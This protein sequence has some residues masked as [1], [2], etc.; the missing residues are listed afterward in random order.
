MPST[1]VIHVKSKRLVLLLVVLFFFSIVIPLLLRLRIREFARLRIY[2]ADPLHVRCR[3]TCQRRYTPTLDDD[4]TYCRPCMSVNRPFFFQGFLRL[5]SYLLN[6]YIQGQAAIQ[7]LM[8]SMTIKSCFDSVLLPL[9][10]CCE[11][12]P[13]EQWEQQREKEVGALVLIE[14]IGLYCG[15]LPRRPYR[16][17]WK[18]TSA[19]TRCIANTHIRYIYLI[20]SYIYI[21]IQRERAREF[22]RSL[23]LGLLLC[24]CNSSQSSIFLPFYIFSTLFYTLFLSLTYIHTQ[25]REDCSMSAII[26][27]SCDDLSSS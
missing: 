9:Y 21:Y 15:A 25:E 5:C 23:W 2:E 16:V 17:V 19:E 11:T 6:I 22:K 24:V 7:T 13:Y 8:L 4:A 20:L 10:I 3:S 1:A 27:R 26:Y 12:Q 18:A 14:C